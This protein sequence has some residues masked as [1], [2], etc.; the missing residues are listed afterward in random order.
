MIYSEFRSSREFIIPF[1]SGLSFLL[2]WLEV[3]KPFNLQIITKRPD[4][5]EKTLRKLP[6]IEK[7]GTSD[8]LLDFCHPFSPNRDNIL[9]PGQ[10]LLQVGNRIDGA[11]INSVQK[12]QIVTDIIP[13]MD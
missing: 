11:G 8:W 12:G 4:L 2:I 3:K 5:H 13:E 9:S 1:L 6:D 7:P 10:V